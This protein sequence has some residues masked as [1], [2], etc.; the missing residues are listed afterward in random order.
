[1]K[2]KIWHDITN[3]QLTND[4][5]LQFELGDKGDFQAILII[6]VSKPFF[7]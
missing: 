3:P 7:H 1:M 6:A 5:N 4:W 2:I